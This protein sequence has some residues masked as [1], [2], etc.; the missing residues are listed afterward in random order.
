[1]NRGKN[2]PKNGG[3]NGGN[4]GG[5]IGGIR[6]SGGMICACESQAKRASAMAEKRIASFMLCCLCACWKFI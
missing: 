5:T 3:M 1:M 2:P 4:S 6:P